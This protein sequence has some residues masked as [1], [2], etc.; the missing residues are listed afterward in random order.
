MESLPELDP[1]RAECHP[2]GVGQLV[3]RDDAVL[4]MVV[5]VASG[6]GGCASVGDPNQRGKRSLVGL[7][8]G[9]GP[10][11][12]AVEEGVHRLDRVHPGEPERPVAQVHPEPEEDRP[13]VA[14]KDDVLD[15]VGA[16]RRGAIGGS[17]AEAR[18]EEDAWPF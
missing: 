9:H 18:G 1:E 3:D 16:G 14:G 11:V 4:G 10:V 17:E 7:I 2:E 8:L 15:R 12:V 6:H 13:V 5:E